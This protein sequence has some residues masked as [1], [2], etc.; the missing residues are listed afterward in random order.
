MKPKDKTSHKANIMAQLKDDLHRSRTNEKQLMD[1]NTEMKK[2]LSSLTKVEMSL[3]KEQFEVTKL[4]NEVDEYKSLITRTRAE[5]N[6]VKNLF[7]DEQ[8]QRVR[9]KTVSDQRIIEVEREFMEMKNQYNAEKKLREQKDKELERFQN[10]NEDYRKLYSQEK[11]LRSEVKQM[12]GFKTFSTRTIEELKKNLHSTEEECRNAKH[13]LSKLKERDI[14]YRS[15]EYEFNICK[16]TLDNCQKQNQKMEQELEKCL[17]HVDA[18]E[19]EINWLR[20]ENGKLTKKGEC[21]SVAIKALEQ[22]VLTLGHTIKSLKDESDTKEKEKEML[23]RAIQH[24]K[25][26]LTTH[27]E[28]KRKL[29]EQEDKNTV[30]IS[31]TDGEIVKLRNLVDDLEHKYKHQHL[32]Y[33]TA[34]SE[35][36]LISQRLAEAEEQLDLNNRNLENMNE[37]VKDL[38][39]D[40]DQKKSELLSINQKLNSAMCRIKKLETK[41]VELK[42]TGTSFRDSAEKEKLQSDKALAQAEEDNK[43]LSKKLALANEQALQQQKKI[44]IL[45]HENEV[46]AQTIKERDEQITSLRKETHEIQ[47]IS[48][49]HFKYLLKKVESCDATRHPQFLDVNILPLRKP[50]HQSENK[51]LQHTLVEYEKEQKEAIASLNDKLANEPDDASW[52][53]ALCQLDIR[54]LLEELK[55]SNA[56]ATTYGT[57]NKKLIEENKSLTDEVRKLKLECRRK[58]KETCLPPLTEKATSTTVKPKDKFEDLKRFPRLPPISKTPVPPAESKK[59]PPSPFSEISCHGKQMC[60]S[61]HTLH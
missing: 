16:N 45:Q 8:T 52:K 25:D 37:T 32:V 39:S 4:Q 23:Q 29:H 31:N 14:L 27:R 2:Q 44:N 11:A 59:A 54:E 24:L 30:L 42:R 43:Q 35:K 13:E 57:H 1:Q 58:S 20:K 21:D 46:L 12:T 41:L 7:R 9:E 48:D 28:L 18:N 5:L 34:L 51:L 56:I 10:I 19:R 40:I 22:R 36:Q 33:R 38:T 55:A 60:Y 26:Q 47:N 49:L 53:L 50:P 61:D 17:K 3:K 6:K 15:Q